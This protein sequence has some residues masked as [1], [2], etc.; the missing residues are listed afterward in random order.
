MKKCRYCQTEIDAKTKIC[1]H[2][3]KK[4]GSG[5]LKIIAIIFVIL[6]IG[7]GCSSL[8]NDTSNLDSNNSDNNSTSS[9]N[10]TEENECYATLDIF[11]SIQNGMTYD[12]VKSLVGC[13][14]T[15]STESSYGDS[16]MQIYYWYAENG[17]SNM[18]ISFTNNEVSA[19]SQIG[20][21]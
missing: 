9:N 13:D 6:F 14:G 20:L 7:V 19:K 5:S 16:S 3:R 17:I 8:L 11:N 15:L 4:Q 2:C 18:T 1:P 10:S 21:D 12:E